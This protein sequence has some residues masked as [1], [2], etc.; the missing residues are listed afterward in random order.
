MYD[1]NARAFPIGMN[2]C[3]NTN[4]IQDCVDVSHGFGCT[5]KF[6]R[7]IYPHAMS[8]KHK[9]HFQDSFMFS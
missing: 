6:G 7:N 1:G 2:I 5:L 4:V 3:I 9:I 8:V